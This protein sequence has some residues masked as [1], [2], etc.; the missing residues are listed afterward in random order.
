MRELWPTPAFSQMRKPIRPL[1]PS[2][3]DGSHGVMLVG[4]VGG[5]NPEYLGLY[6]NPRWVEWLM[7][8]PMGWTDL[9]H[10]ETQ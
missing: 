9:N 2:E 5:R 4:A 8:Y 7:G 1:A 3:K 6:L 10:S